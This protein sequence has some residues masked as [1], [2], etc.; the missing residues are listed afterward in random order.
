[1]REQNM[2]WEHQHIHGRCRLWLGLKTVAVLRPFNYPMTA[3][4]GVWWEPSTLKAE[5][6]MSVED[7]KALIETTVAMRGY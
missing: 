1:M 6:G 5:K 7:F 4:V 3:T 2:E